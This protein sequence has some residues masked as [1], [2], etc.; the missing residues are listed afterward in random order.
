ME[1]QKKQELY[2]KL[3]TMEDTEETVQR[4]WRDTMRQEEEHAESIWRKRRTAEGHF[5]SIYS[6]D[7]ELYCILEEKQ[8]VI[9]SIQ[10]EQEAFIEEVDR[11]K[12]KDIEQLE[13]QR[14]EL[15]SQLKK[16]D[17]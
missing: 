14:Y 5:E 11:K 10:R 12:R 7:P 17:K 6:S 8:D 1:E 16:L 9:V 15:Q 3:R 13:W 4:I 2:S